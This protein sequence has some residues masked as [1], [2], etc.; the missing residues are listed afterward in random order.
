M[1]SK[2]KS[3]IKINDNYMDSEFVANE[4][5]VPEI[6][7]ETKKKME[8]D[9]LFQKENKKLKDKFVKTLSS[10]SKSNLDAENQI[11]LAKYANV[12]IV[13]EREWRKLVGMYNTI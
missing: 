12:S 5:V 4:A 8:D 1:K 2:S 13:T 9:E 6:D 10:G 7:E 11:N 3:N